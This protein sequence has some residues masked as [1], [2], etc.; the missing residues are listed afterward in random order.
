MDGLP[1][2]RPLRVRKDVCSECRG[3][4]SITT[5][6]P[7]ATTDVSDSAYP[8]ETCIDLALLN[9]MVVKVDKAHGA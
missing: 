8:L 2:S 3:D 7:G 1:S 5:Y 4:I 9:T 6:R